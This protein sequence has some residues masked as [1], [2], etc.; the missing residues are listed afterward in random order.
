MLALMARGKTFGRAIGGTYTSLEA[1]AHSYSKLL[2]YV[3]L[4]NQQHMHTRT[5]Q[6]TQGDMR[7]LTSSHGGCARHFQPSR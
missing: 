1:T 4:T 2:T 3:A 5:V 7:L 6:Q